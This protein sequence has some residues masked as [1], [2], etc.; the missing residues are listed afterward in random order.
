MIVDPRHG[1]PPDERRA[2]RQL[3]AAKNEEVA[4]SMIIGSDQIPDR[5][6]I[7]ITIVPTEDTNLAQPTRISRLLM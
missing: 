4:S 5:S 3:W 2:M 6:T 7:V 1:S